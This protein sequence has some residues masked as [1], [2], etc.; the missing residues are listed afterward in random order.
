MPLRYQ[1][2]ASLDANGLEKDTGLMFYE[3]FREQF[4]CYAQLLYARRKAHYIMICP[5]SPML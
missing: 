1:M 4:L 5:Y 2:R 3:I